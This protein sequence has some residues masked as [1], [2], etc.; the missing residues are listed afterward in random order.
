MGMNTQNVHFTKVTRTT[1]TLSIAVSGT[2]QVMAW[3]AVI[4]GGNPFALWV[5]G[6]PNRITIQKNG[7]YMLSAGVEFAAN[8]TGDREIYFNKN[9]VVTPIGSQGNKSPTLAGRISTSTFIRLARGEFVETWVNQTSTAALNVNT[10]AAGET[11]YFSVT[12]MRPD[13][14]FVT[15]EVIPG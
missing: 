6:S 12:L 7:W 14:D 9:G 1:A 13:Y 10:T 15:S 5:V 2:P 3:E 11:P 8:A 4:V